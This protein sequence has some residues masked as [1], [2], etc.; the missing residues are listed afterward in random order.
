MIQLPNKEI[1]GGTLH[2]SIPLQALSNQD[3]GMNGVID[4]RHGINILWHGKHRSRNQVHFTLH[5]PSHLGIATVICV[6]L[7]LYN[8]IVVELSR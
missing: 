2:I 7:Y 3:Q 4:N 8:K 6:A 1:P 5:S